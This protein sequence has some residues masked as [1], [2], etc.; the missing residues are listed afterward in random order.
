MLYS[1]EK[2]RSNRFKLALRMGL[3]VFILSCL[4]IFFF[5][6]QSHNHLTTSFYIGAL[7][8]L[9]IM[10]YFLF[11]M[12]YI[13]FNERIIEPI[14]GAFTREYISKLLQEAISKKE[15][16]VL[17]VS[18]QNMQAINDRYGI[19][20]GDAVLFEI[21][22]SLDILFEI[23]KLPIGHL[24]GADFLIGLEGK[25][26]NYKE[27]LDFLHLK[28]TNYN[29][30]NIEVN[31]GFTLEDNSFSKDL[32]RLIDYL[33]WL[34]TLQK[35][36]KANVQSENFID[37]ESLESS[38]VQALQS[39]SFM[40]LSQNVYDKSAA[41]VMEDISVKLRFDGKIIHQKTYKAVINRLGLSYEFD[42]MIL[43]KIA[44]KLF[45]S[46]KKYAMEIAPTTLRDSRFLP[47]LQRL[48]ATYA[49]SGK[50]V[51][52]LSETTYYAN[53]EY[54]Q[55]IITAARSLGAAVAL[56]KFCEYH[57]S[58]LY[59]RDLNVDMVRFDVKY[60]KK[61]HLPKYKTILTGVCSIL[62]NLQILSWMKLL[63]NEAH[64]EEVQ[65]IDL[66]LRQG[67]F[68]DTL[69]EIE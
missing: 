34:Q 61:L 46:E 59:F 48:F 20:N 26:E 1:E 57:T 24:K 33:L 41:V 7:F 29:I 18:V 17:L 44:P 13:G 60:A 55:E 10:I 40:L 58:F 50:I 11:Y 54:F 32:N 56:D 28:F 66:D 47:Q 6:E 52:L 53:N 65:K 68:F 14:T 23:K 21:V 30:K 4:A 67:K 51:F 39:G 37:P 16:S 49:L 12:I 22:R 62:H 31:I 69:K 38:V 9:L 36:S 45:K 42:M 19:K 8:I 25:K 27:K 43:N 3:P 35:P 5:V 15:Y 63:E 64:C 2:E